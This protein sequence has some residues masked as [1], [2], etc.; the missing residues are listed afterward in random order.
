MKVSYGSAFYEEMESPNARSA[1]VVVPLVASYLGLMPNRVVDIGC[2]RG[3]WLKAFLGQGATQ[4]DGYDGEYVE[5]EKLAI[6]ASCF[7]AANLEESIAFSAPYNLAVCLEVAEHLPAKAA[8]TLI[9]TLTEA[10]P[11][12]L[13]SAAIPLQGGSHHVN[14]QWPEYWEKKFAG[15]GYVP[16][17]CLRRHMWSDDRISFFYQQ[18]MLMFVKER[19][20]ANYP[21]LLAEREN[22]H[23]KALALVHPHMYDYYAKRW[24][25]IEPFLWK[26]PLPL[27]KWGKRI[28]M[29]K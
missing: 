9:K 22:G 14:E 13:F 20:L 4:V 10:A 24:H 29:C 19:E 3:L 6:P 25:S 5:R 21:K 18:N 1:R 7:H 16:V 28:L 15:R 2:G 12:V 23:D 17:D 27:V 8:D 11:V 26:L